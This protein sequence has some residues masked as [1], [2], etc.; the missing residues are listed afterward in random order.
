MRVLE[1]SKTTIQSAATF[2][3]HTP[4]T[5]WRNNGKPVLK[6]MHAFALTC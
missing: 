1:Q 3:K 6:S 2:V 5:C 4:D